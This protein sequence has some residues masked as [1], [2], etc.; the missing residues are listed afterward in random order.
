MQQRGCAPRCIEMKGQNC[1]ERSSSRG[2]VV[3]GAKERSQ[4][5]KRA[6][7]A[8][9]RGWRVGGAARE[10]S[11]PLK[12]SVSGL[13]CWQQP[14]SGVGGQWRL[15]KGQ[16]LVVVASERLK[17]QKWATRRL[18]F[19]VGGQK[20]VGTLKRSIRCS[21]SGLGGWWEVGTPKT[22]MNTRFRSWKVV[23]VASKDGLNP[24]NE[25]ECSFSGLGEVWCWNS[26][27]FRGSEPIGW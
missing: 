23:V 1:K 25:Y 18:V 19:K 16:N 5:W 11:Q 7:A 10:R 15:K 21:F 17:P 22:S 14:E 3:V 8:R 9:F 4:P 20:K 27:E 6:L 24:E 12:T 13:G 26:P 2:V